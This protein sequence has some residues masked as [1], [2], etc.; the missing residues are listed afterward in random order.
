MGLLDFLFPKYCVNCRKVGDYICSD[1][2]SYVSFAPGSKCLVCDRACFNG[3]THPN[4]VSKYTIDGAFSS[5]EYKGVIKKLVYS[6]K[7]KPYVS[8]LQKIIASLLTEGLIQNEYFYGV[9]QK[10]PDIA[11]VPI[12]L[13]SS[14]LKS[15]GYNQSEILACLLGKQLNVSVQNMLTR[16]KKTTPQFGLK[17]EERFKNMEEAFEIK[18][19][20]AVRDKTILLVDDVLT[21]GATLSAAARIL[22]KSGAKKVFG[23]TLAID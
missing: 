22:K 20:Q 2:F 1:C 15:R 7:Y 8:D 13:H 4:C 21:T 5:V 18:A 9:L 17:R 6:F 14:K 12:P 3:Y 10:Y 23:I 19:V 16:G 11:I